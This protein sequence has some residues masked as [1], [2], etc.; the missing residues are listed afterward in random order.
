MRKVSRLFVAMI[1]IVFVFLAVTTPV[2]SQ[3]TYLRNTTNSASTDTINT[4]STNDTSYTFK[5]IGYKDVWC[6]AVQNST[7]ETFKINSVTE[8]QQLRTIYNAAD[9]SLYIQ[10]KGLLGW[11]P[12]PIMLNTS[13]TQTN[14]Y[15]LSAKTGTGVLSF[16]IKD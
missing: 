12:V 3:E 13:A 15:P 11:F 8:N 9:S 16:A 7:K 6:Q 4:A 5:N 1:L 2:K 10:E 14:K